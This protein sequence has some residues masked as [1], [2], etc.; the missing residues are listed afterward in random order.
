MKIIE[1]LNDLKAATGDKQGEA[2]GLIFERVQDDYITKAD[3]EGALSKFKLE[4]QRWIFMA[5]LA[6][7]AL[8]VTIIGIINAVVYISLSGSFTNIL[9][10]ALTHLK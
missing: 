5:L 2:I 10:N 3:L 4:M 8:T 6:Q 9:N 1:A 7:L